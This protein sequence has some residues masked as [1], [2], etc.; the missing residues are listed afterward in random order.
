MQ[1]EIEV[2]CEPETLPVISLEDLQDALERG[3]L[4]PS[5]FGLLAELV[6]HREQAD[7]SEAVRLAKLVQLPQVEDSRAS[8]APGPPGGRVEYSV[9]APLRGSGRYGEELRALPGFGGV[10]ATIHA[11]REQ[12]EPWVVTEAFAEWRMGA[13]LLQ[14]G[15]LHPVWAGG[16]VVGRSPV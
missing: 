3:D 7:S 6:G 8:R 2:R 4:T 14:A 16:L 11:R 9:Y 13:A 10:S 5:E 15:S 12:A 1:P